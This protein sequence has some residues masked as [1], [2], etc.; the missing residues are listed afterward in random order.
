MPKFFVPREN[1]HGGEIIIKGADAAH[2]ARVLRMGEGDTLSLCDGRGFD[3]AAR[4]E[5]AQPREIVCRITQTRRSDTEPNIRVTLFQ[6]IPK[7]SKM[8][9]IIQ[10]TTELGVSKIVPCRMERCVAKID[11]AGDEAKKLERWRK[12]AESAAKQSGRGII[13]EIGNIVSVEEAAKRLGKCEIA[14]APYECE[15]SLGIKSFLKS[16]P[17]ETDIGFIIGPEGGFDM[18]EIKL[19]TDAGIKSV[20]L[21]KRIL[22]TE[23]AGEAVLA[24]VM[25]EKGDIS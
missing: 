12:I 11:S 16:C 4:I 20:T 9:Y 2:I 3:Y 5:R 8:E 23:T 21:G 15:E 25:Y 13:P 22:R 24:M 10:K 6:G 18:K 1:I 7:A 17:D 14:F 19:L